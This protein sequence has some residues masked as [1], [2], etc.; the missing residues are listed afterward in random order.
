MKRVGVGCVLLLVFLVLGV[1]VSP[2]SIDM[3]AVSVIESGQ[4][5]MARGRD[6]EYG[7]CQ[8]MPGTW[9]EFA[10]KGEKWSNPKDNKA[11]AMRYITW[12]SKTLKSWGDPGWNKPSHIMAS[13]N[14]GINLF[15]KVHFRVD[16]MP[17]ST[18]NY[19]KKYE[20]LCKK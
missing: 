2:A 13:Y 10:R 20:R 17:K 6:G 14:G 8:V 11:V 15:R 3:K 18:Q 7:L 1:L 16:R 19:V 4:N 5:P 9:R 12:I